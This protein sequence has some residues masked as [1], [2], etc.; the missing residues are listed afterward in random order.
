MRSITHPFTTTWRRAKA[1]PSHL[2]ECY[3]RYK[4][5]RPFQPTD[6]IYRQAL[7]L[8]RADFS[9]PKIHPMH[10]N[11]VIRHYQHPE[12]SPGLPYTTQGFKR[13]DEVDPNTIKWSVHC[14]KYKIWSRCKTPCNAAS[15]TAVSKDKDKVR[16]IWVY[17][18]HMTFAEGMFAMPLLHAYKQR[19]GRYGIWIKYL[20]GHMRYMLSLKP[21][22]YTWLAADWSNFDASVPAWLIRDAFDILR[23]NLDFS[24]YQ[25]RGAPTHEDSL[26]N[27][28]K[29]IVRY[30]INTPLKLPTGEVVFKSGGVPSGSYF[31]S[32]IDSVINCIV[33]HH[34]MLSLKVDYSHSAFWV[35]GDDVL[36]AISKP[37]NVN[38]LAAI[39]KRV[40]GM[41]LNEEKTEIGT[42]PSFL[43]FGLH[44][45]GVPQSN[46][47]RLMA[48]LCLPSRPDR[49][50]GELAARIRALQLASFG[51]NKRF[52][53]ETQLYLESLGM[54]HPENDLSKRDEHRVKLEYLGLAS[55]PPLARVLTL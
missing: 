29:A 41:T 33:T 52:L 32:L 37:C 39:A 27:L 31:T 14:L 48:Q 25:F 20:H 17:P 16:L 23:S 12:R 2:L 7:V 40:F 54:P 55:W 49:S 6:E 22:N 15:R 1:T 46:Y 18:S 3:Q 47:D 28:W 24:Q 5:S 9:I 11:D 42:Y 35:Y 50:L 8:A 26:P 34:L 43:G 4:V 36:I 21:K 30:F 13:K 51:G 53:Y 45:T 44:Y 10:V 38:E 19:K